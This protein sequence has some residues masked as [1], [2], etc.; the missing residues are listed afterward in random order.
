MLGSG[1]PYVLGYII[2]TNTP[3]L[4]ILIVEYSLTPEL[5]IL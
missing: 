2:F 3:E 1:I 5:R 4:K